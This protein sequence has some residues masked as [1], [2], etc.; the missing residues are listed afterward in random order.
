MLAMSF[1]LRQ[2]GLK[3][4]IPHHAYV[5]CMHQFLKSW[6]NKMSYQIFNYIFSSSSILSE[7]LCLYN[8][9]WD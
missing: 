7:V 8:T 2:R 3:T 4:S 6:D 5:Y 9:S 1:M